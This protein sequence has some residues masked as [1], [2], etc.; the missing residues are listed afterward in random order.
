[1]KLS[2]HFSLRELTKSSVANRLRIQ[3]QPGALETKNLQKVCNAIL[4]PV[5]LHYG[6]PFS[7]SSGYRSP[8]LNK[9]VGSK[10]TS[11][12]MKGQ[13]VDFEVPG[14][15]N[16]DL[17]LWVKENCPFDQLILEFFQADSPSSG[18]VHASFVSPQKNRKEA[19]V[20]DGSHWLNF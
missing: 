18:W 19:L 11:Q 3:N 16:L 14:V 10:N 13:A 15:R 12:H 17:A 8:N 9:A 7:P 1:V 4:E 2:K 20:F 6:I 5:R